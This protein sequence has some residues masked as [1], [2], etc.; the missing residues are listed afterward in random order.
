[1]KRDE[2]RGTGN[3]ILRIRD[4]L[5]D[6]GQLTRDKNMRQPI[7]QIGRKWQRFRPKRRVFHSPVSVV[8][9]INVAL[10]IALFMVLD[11]AFVLQPGVMVQLPV[12]QF[13]S[14]SH[15]GSMVVTL[16]Q[17][18]MVF[19]NDERMPIEGLLFAL[20]QEAHQNQDMTLIIEADARVPYGMVIRVMNIA[21]AVRIRHVNLAVRSSFGEE[22]I[23]N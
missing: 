21:T 16:T 18:G 17:E 22:M 10:V 19:F 1:V 7:E 5:E 3:R 2:E 23:K 12:S 15:Y 11:S 4:T 8:P 6:R 20:S 9:L 13:V 14:G